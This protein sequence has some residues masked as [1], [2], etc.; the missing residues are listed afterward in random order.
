MCTPTA[1][2]IHLMDI[3]TFISTRGGAART[4]VLIAAGFSRNRIDAA[5]QNGRVHRIRR[6]VYGIQGGT[7][8]SQAILLNARLTCLSA[9]PIYGLWALQ[10]AAGLHLSAGHKAVAGVRHGPCRHPAHPCLPVAGLADVLLH[11]LRCLP[12]LEA[13]V[14]V[15]SAVSQGS[16]TVDFLRRKLPGNRNGAARSVLDLVIPRADSL[17]E[18]LA[19]THFVRAGLLVRM[20]V[21][22]PGVGEVDCLVEDCLVVEFDGGTHMEPKQVKK[23]QRRNNAAL[24]AGLLPLRF[25]YDDVVHHPERMV[26]QVL[27]VL[28]LHRR[29]GFA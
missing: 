27:E 29:G 16:I 9:G 26:A 1:V 15:Q 24:R 28:E 20:H 13:L 23:D 22:V 3:G 17:L 8:L 2:Q 12:E 10:P 6:G 7:S 11:A 21:E 14:M 25:Y 18:V 5:I 19:R 4:S